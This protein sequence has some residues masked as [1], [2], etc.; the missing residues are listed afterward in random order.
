MTICPKCNKEYTDRPAISREDNK[1]E[2]CPCCGRREA[3]KAWNDNVARANCFHALEAA[4]KVKVRDYMLIDDIPEQALK[5]PP[6]ITFGDLIDIAHEALNG[7]EFADKTLDGSDYA[8]AYDAAM[9]WFEEKTIGG[10][11]TAAR[12]YILRALD[13]LIGRAVENDIKPQQLIA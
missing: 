9:D 3:I 5:I 4:A 8:R 10:I 2:I 1:T 11:D 6:E 7:R 12:D 13:T